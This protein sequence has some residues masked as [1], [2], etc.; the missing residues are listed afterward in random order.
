[1]HIH[2]SLKIFSMHAKWNKKI[3]TRH[4]ELKTHVGNIRWLWDH[5]TVTSE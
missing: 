3:K 5:S 4:K 2:D 1:M